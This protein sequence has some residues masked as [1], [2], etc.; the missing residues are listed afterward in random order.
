MSSVNIKINLITKAAELQLQKLGAT[1]KGT[2]DQ[3]ERAGRKTKGFGKNLGQS[4]RQASLAFGRFGTL[5]RAGIIGGSLF[6]LTAV[7]R[8]TVTSFKEFET[9]LVGVGKTSDLNAEQ[10]A[11]FG[12]SIQNLGNRIPVS[13]NELLKLA[14][15]A[16]QLGVR[17]ERNLRKFAET[18]ARLAVATNVGAEEAVTSLSRIIG[19]TGESQESIENL[20]SSLVQLGNT[21]KANE[22]EILT[23]ARRISQ[24][25]A[26]FGL[27]GSEVIAFGAALKEAGLQAESGGTSVGVFF[28]QLDKAIAKGGPL[29]DN[30]AKISGVTREELIKTFREDGAEALTIFLEGLGRLPPKSSELT[31]ALE[32]TGLASRRTAQTFRALSQISDR[33][34][35]SVQSSNEEFANSDALLGESNKQFNTLAGNL[36]KLD[37]AFTTLF[38]NIGESNEGFLKDFTE[39]LAL[40]FEELGKL[41]KVDP[42]LERLTKEWIELQNAA[43]RARR[44]SKEAREEI[45]E[46]STG[47]FFGDVRRALSRLG[48]ESKSFKLIQAD[49]LQ[50]QA[51]AV[52]AQID[53]I[54]K[55][56]DELNKPTTTDGGTPGEAQIRARQELN[57]ELL[58]LEA[59]YQALSFEQQLIAE[60][61]STAFAKA[62]AEERLNL[63]LDYLDQL[64]IAKI[65]A[66]AKERAATAETEEEKT[67]ILEA[68]QKKRLQLL[69]NNISRELSFN[70]QK[71]EQEKKLD[72]AKLSAT[73][74]L[75]GAIADLAAAGGKKTFAIS[76]AFAKAEALISGYQAVQNALATK[77][78]VLG[79]TLAAAATIRT[80]ANV[81]RINSTQAPAFEQGGI[82]PG[83]SFAGDNITARVNSGEMILNRAQQARLFAQANGGAPTTGNGQEVVVHTTVE[84]DGEA[85]TKAVSRQ[86]ANGVE[87]GEFE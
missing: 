17:G 72:A 14:Q 33:V 47:T 19:I 61:E 63:E 70:K 18:G 41:A 11:A 13:T 67:K 45:V 3:I 83:N 62:A 46:P 44:A 39:N 38:T 52:K 6:G 1:A 71:L 54:K 81:A 43:N 36:G 53:E 5:L 22:D 29:L 65:E 32:S 59:E 23:A 85:V 77:P 49:D 31:K 42:K 87:L 50:K 27:A 2:A 66:D 74:S 7:V 4:F 80:A 51:D 79:L 15:V 28:T 25:T 48:E 30:F 9:A 20:G 78:F 58:R 69:N 64:E 35:V 26:G 34:R 37:N 60:G 73:G 76:K 10:L 57:I 40:I 82:V 56:Q 68:G 12:R 86:V 84:I 21:F 16:A 24:S 8:K 75:F 55:K